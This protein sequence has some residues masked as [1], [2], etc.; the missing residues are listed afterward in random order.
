MCA[1]MDSGTRE[2]P[3]LL[4]NIWSEKYSVCVFFKQPSSTK[5]IEESDNDASAGECISETWQHFIEVI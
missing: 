2:T 5:V 4:S 3:L 1:L